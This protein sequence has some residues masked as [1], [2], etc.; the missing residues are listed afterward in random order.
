M[1]S[2]FPPSGFNCV[3][4]LIHLFSHKIII[5]A[6]KILVCSCQEKKTQKL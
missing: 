3:G 4:I 6:E 2:N 1:E 5:E